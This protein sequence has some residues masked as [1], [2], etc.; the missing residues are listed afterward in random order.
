MPYQILVRDDCTEAMKRLPDGSV[1]SVVCDPPYHLTSIVERF[2]K[3]DAA[4]VKV[5]EGGSGVYARSSKGFMGKTW[6]G[7]DVAFR[8]STWEEAYR[9][10]KPG[11]HLLAFGGTRTYHRM[12][13]AIEDAGFEIRDSIHYTYGCLSEDTEILVNGE[14]QPYH[15]ASAGSLALC[16]DAEQDTYAWRPVENLVVYEYDDTAYRI[17]SEDTE[18]VVSRNH[19]CLV[20]SNDGW[21]FLTAE[22]VARQQ[23][24]RV[25]FLQDVRGLLGHLRVHEPHTGEAQPLLSG[26]RADET[27]GTSQEEA[28]GGAYRPPHGGLC[29]VWD[30]SSAVSVEEA[31]A[32]PGVLSQM[33]RGAPGCGVEGTRAQ[34]PGCV[35]TGIGGT[36]PGA[37]DGSV[38]PGVEGR[39]DV[40][41]AQRELHRAEVRSLPGA[42][43]GDGSE[44][45][46]CDGASASRRA[47]SCANADT[48]RSG[49][50]RQP[51][52]E[53]QQPLELDAVSDER[54]AQE[55][56]GDRF[57]GTT[58]AR[59]TPIHYTGVVWCVKVPTGAFV[60]RRNGKV[61]VTG[62]SGFPKSHAVDKN[63]P[64]EHAGAWKGWGTALKP[65]HEVIVLARKPLEG[66]VAK[67]VL[68]HG[69]G[70]LNID[71]T[72]VATTDNLNGGAYAANP[73]ERTIS[74]LN[75]RAGDENVFRRGGAGEFVQ[76]EGRWP[77]NTLLQHSPGCGEECDEGCPALVMDEQSGGD[78]ASRY[79]NV[80]ALEPGEYAPFFYAPKAARKEREA[81]LGDFKTEEKK[82]AND[83]PTVKSIALMEWCVKLVTPP[84]GVV[85]DPFMGS[86]STGIAALRN[87]FNFIGMEADEHYMD[88]A[89]ARIRHHGGTPE[90]LR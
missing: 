9:V 57:T 33:Q 14:W 28:A 70:A 16:Y 58:L 21:K 25:P 67:N 62:N 11:G 82:V 52:P 68:K 81:G 55:V 56:R 45:R 63:V 2:G 54:G 1:H 84:D 41:A 38:Q 88:I 87:G 30:A 23:E 12:A 40:Q 46:V 75:S 32:Q 7:G 6:D 78:G 79:F 8:V 31:H 26:V 43:Q 74:V 89:E 77:A 85:L 17:E 64:E 5:P 37:H 50:S 66:T 36:L 53:G 35:G 65:S 34:G 44:G 29:G 76:P 49:A 13:C 20:R 42:V 39:G 90:V 72:R 4:A 24:A 69:T 19:R 3:E 71:A 61:F 10:L 59:V 47:G 27:L 80:F 86:G 18:Q 83:H 60:A 51:R 15:K 48:G 73:T 22:E